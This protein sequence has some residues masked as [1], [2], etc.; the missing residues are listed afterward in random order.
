MTATTT[1]GNK[2]QSETLFV[3]GKYAV[4]QWPNK[5]LLCQRTRSRQIPNMRSVSQLADQK[6][7]NQGRALRQFL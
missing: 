6:K 2:Y 4:F 5:T 3:V 7:T 1:F